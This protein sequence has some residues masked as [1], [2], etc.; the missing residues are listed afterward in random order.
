[1]KYSAHIKIG[2][3]SITTEEMKKLPDQF[4]DPNNPT[5][6]E[7]NAYFADQQESYAGS[8]DGSEAIANADIEYEKTESSASAGEDEDDDEDDDEEEEFDDEEDDDEDD[9]DDDD[10]E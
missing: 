5:D 10:D 9:E 7:L 2:L 8:N 4:K 1:M 6:K 3:G